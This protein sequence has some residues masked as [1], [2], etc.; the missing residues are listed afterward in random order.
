MPFQMISALT[1]RI[2]GACALVAAAGVWLPAQQPGGDQVPLF[3]GGTELVQID[4]S[5]LDNRRRPVKGLT[6][7][8][9]TVL[10][11][12]QPRPVEAFSEIDLPPRRSTADASWMSE[13]PADVVSNRAIGEEGRLVVIL[14]D[15]TIP[16]GMPTVTAREVATAAVNELGPGDMAA[17]VSTSGGVP[18]NF[19]A[20]RSLLLR[21]ITQRDWSTGI[22]EEAREIEAVIFKATPGLFTNLTDGRCLCGLCVPESVTRVAEALQNVPRRRKSL[23]FIGSDFVVQAGLG[24]E[25]RA[26][27]GCGTKLKDAREKM[28]GALDRSG[29]IV[30][31]IDPSGLHTVGPISRASS[32]VRGA[33]VGFARS[34]AVDENLASQNN[35]H[36]VPDHTGGRTVMNTN[37]PQARMPDIMR[38]SQSYYLLGFRPSSPDPAR[39]SQSIQVKVNRRN[40]DVQTRRLLPAAASTLAGAPPSLAALNGLLPDAQLPLDLHVAAFATPQAERPSVTV[41]VGIDAFAPPRDAEVRNTPLEVVVG[42]FDP[43]GQPRASARQ[44]LELSWPVSGPDAGRRVEAV[45]RLALDPGEYEVRVAVENTRSKQVSSVFSYLT[46]PPFS[47]VP[48]SLST[49]V[50]DA[51][52]TTTS[53]PRDA[54]RGLLPAPPTTTRAFR[55]DETVSA[56]MRV[57]Q[58]TARDEALSAVAVRVQIVDGQNRAVHDEVMPLGAAA[59]QGPRAA[60]CRIPLPVSQLAPGEY[61]LRVE[62][63]MGKRVAGRAMRFSVQ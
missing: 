50:V 51:P 29:V 44:T 25:P 1:I 33:D 4:V 8:D 46:V 48:L 37:A 28:F 62:A 23:L 14:M 20:D 16:V 31:A 53:V 57:Y 54:L 52:R 5:V 21:A 30:H 10:E 45:T 2:A 35:L 7:A 9:F 18:Q 63:T 15:R 34:R 55:R 27:L 22:S 49:I 47:S 26:E 13:V 56:F 60:D 38:E 43:T 6:A 40:V 12:G 59:F 3:R 11:G 24:A 32:T 41:A 58:G 61:L 17:V 42:A 36:I 19:T 39:R